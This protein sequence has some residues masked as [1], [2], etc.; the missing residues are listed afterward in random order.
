[1]DLFRRAKS[2]IL[3][4]VETMK[5]EEQVVL[6]DLARQVEEKLRAMPREQAIKMAQE[7][8]KAASSGRPGGDVA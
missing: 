5:T 2:P 7:L 6:D 1:M 3:R 4:V 8:R